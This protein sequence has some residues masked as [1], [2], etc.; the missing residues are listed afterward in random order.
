MELLVEGSQLD[1][2]ASTII[3]KVPSTIVGCIGQ[4]RLNILPGQSITDA[5]RYSFT[6]QPCLPMELYGRN[7]FVRVRYKVKKTNGED[8]AESEQVRERG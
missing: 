6:L 3:S 5:N 2:P 8:F 1:I 7:S 4:A